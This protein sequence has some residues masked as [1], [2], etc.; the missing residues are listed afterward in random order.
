MTIQELINALTE[1][2]QITDDTLAVKAST[3]SGQVLD[4]S[5]IIIGD[6]GNVQIAVRA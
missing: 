3:V 1:A 5:G 4:I 6:E 2:S